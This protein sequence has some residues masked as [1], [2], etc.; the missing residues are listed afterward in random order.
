MSGYIYASSGFGESTADLVFAGNALI[1]EAGNLLA[2]AERFC[3]DPQLAISEIDVKRL[4]SERQATTSFMGGAAALR[5]IQPYREVVIPNIGSN[6]IKLTRKI[7]ASPFVPTDATALGDVC[8][9]AFNIHVSAL[10]KRIKHTHTKTL[11]LGISGG[12]DSTLALL[13]CVEALRRI[14]RPLTDI[15]GITMPGFGTS[16]R[17]HDNAVVLMR[18][19]G[20]TQREISIVAYRWK[21]DSDFARRCDLRECSSA[22]AHS[23]T[24]G[25]CQPN[26]WY[27]N[28]YRRPFGTCTRVG[29]LQWRPHVN[30]WRVGRCAQNTCA[31]TCQVGRRAMCQ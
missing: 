24:H 7:E 12:L 6:A 9:E 10:L 11:V 2:T 28:R 5:Q 16:D 13:V 23:N 15:V 31:C 30:V 14:G 3:I 4:N 1:Y 8:Q 22:R 26:R 20:I 27:C 18:E 17:T 19:L 21:F 25:C 29:Y